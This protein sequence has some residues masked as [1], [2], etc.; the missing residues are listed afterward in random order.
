MNHIDAIGGI[1]TTASHNPIQYNGFKFSRLEAKP[2][3][4][5]TGLESIQAYAEEDDGEDPV[6]GE[7]NMDLWAQYKVHV[8]QFLHP[9]LL[10]GKRTMKVVID[11]SNGMAGTFMPTC[12]GMSRVSR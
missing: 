8:H 10:S 12:S 11:A 9:D 3:G 1:Q 7:S 4:M 2:I 6:G 5:G